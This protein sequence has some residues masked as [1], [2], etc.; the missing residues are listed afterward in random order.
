[1]GSQEN[2]DQ[3]PNDLTP[4]KTVPPEPYASLDQG[5]KQNGPRPAEQ[6]D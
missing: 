3:S 2:K 1:M 4:G 5:T 6:N